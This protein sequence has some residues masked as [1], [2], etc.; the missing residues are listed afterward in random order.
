MEENLGWGIRF[1]TPG[2]WSTLTWTGPIQ[3]QP[4]NI[5]P[6][7]KAPLCSYAL[8]FDFSFCITSIK[9]RCTNSLLELHFT[10]G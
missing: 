9:G 5:G 10:F 3:S 6:K 4:K 7:L 1:K 8:N 2:A